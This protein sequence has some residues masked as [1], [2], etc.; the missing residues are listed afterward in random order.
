MQSFDADNIYAYPQTGNHHNVN[1]TIL[2][3]DLASLTFGAADQWV[4][5]A[6]QLADF[7]LSNDTF[8]IPVFCVYPISSQ[9][10]VLPRALFYLLLI[11]SLVFRRHTLLS[12]AALATTMTYSATAVIHVF[13]LLAQ[14]RFNTGPGDANSAKEY[15]DVD[16]LAIF[17]IL[18]A[19]GIMLAPILNWST[20]IRRHRA[21]AIIIWWGI[22]IFVGLVPAWIYMYGWGEKFDLD[23]LESFAACPRTSDSQCDFGPDWSFE[24]DFTY[25]LFKRCN[26]VDFCAT[27]SPTAPMRSGSNMVAWIGRKISWQIGEGDRVWS[28]WTFSWIVLIFIVL[29]GIFGIIA[30]RSSPASVRNAFFKFLSS[31]RRQWIQV[32]FEGRRQEKLLD[33]FHLTTHKPSPPTGLRRLR[34]HIAKYIAAGIYLGSVAG[35]MLSPAIFVTTVVSNELLLGM[36]P[37]SEHHDAVGAWAPWVSVGLVLFAAV[38]DRYFR[39]LL[40]SMRIAL[41]SLWSVV[42]YSAL[43]RREFASNVQTRETLRHRFAKFNQEISIPFQHAWHRGIR[44]T[45]HARVK[46]AEFAWWWKNTEEA[47][48]LNDREIR[49]WQKARRPKPKCAC[50]SCVRRAE[51]R[52]NQK[53]ETRKRRELSNQP[54]DSDNSEDAAELQTVL[55]YLQARVKRR[56]GPDYHIR[57]RPR[58]GFASAEVLPLPGYTKADMRSPPLDECAELP[59]YGYLL[60]R[61]KRR[62][63]E[64]YEIVRMPGGGDVPMRYLAREA[65]GSWQSLDTAYASPVSPESASDRQRLF[66]DGWKQ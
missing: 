40:I 12:T 22:L 51:K 2:P 45:W 62:L 56:L 66:Q 49:A 58:E 33:K 39:P 55:E 43:E 47:S 59:N 11:L 38:M 54:Y 53:A 3:N 20:T 16:L 41:E 1:L 9:Y 50:F 7:V 5:T 65:E 25:A 15:G 34:H 57:R 64:N 61:V 8:R 18:A 30:S 21:Q 35:A 19:A 4:T 23:T 37:V 32:L 63:G 6:F 28:L 24:H 60:K 52:E 44:L 48:A 26:C 46:V 31:G 17:P 42:R 13:A 14:Y 29:Y 27:L 10:D 36:Y